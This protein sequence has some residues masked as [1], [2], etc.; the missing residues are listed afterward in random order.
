MAKPPRPEKGS[1]NFARTGARQA[2]LRSRISGG[3]VMGQSCASKATRVFGSASC[4]ACSKRVS[5][6]APITHCLVS[7]TQ[8]PFKATTL[9]STHHATIVGVER[10]PGALCHHRRHLAL[11]QHV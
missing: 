1:L 7:K 6:G 2:A 3:I 4:K 8:Q 10:I 9:H 5:W 11:I